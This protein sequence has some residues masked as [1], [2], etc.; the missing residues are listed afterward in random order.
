LVVDPDAEDIYNALGGIYSKLGRHEEA[1]AMMQRYVQL[2][3]DEP[4]AYDSLALIYQWAGQYDR[5][6]QAYH[7][8][9]ALKPDFEISIVNLG[10]LYFQ[11]GRYRTAINQYERYL[12]LARSDMER[13]K[14]YGCLAWVYLKQG[15][16]EKAEAAARKELEYGQGSSVGNSLIAALSRG[17]HQR[18]DELKAQLF[19]ASPYTHRGARPPLR[20]L[21]Y[22]LG[23]YALK[24]GQTAEAI[25][26]FQ[27]ALKHLP[28]LGA[29]DLLEDCL[30]NAY[31][32]LGQPD[33]AIAEYERVLK[34]NPHYPLA[35]YHLGQAYDRK[36][37]RERARTAYERFLQ[38]WKDA[39]PGIPEVME[40]KARVGREP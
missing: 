30:A 15:D 4:N 27:K 29:A 18:A 36:G 11:Q 38:I 6:Q 17:D 26:Q 3:P 16:L 12:K 19:A 7:R 25:A 32:E 9:L 24:R 22:F 20:Y 5:A 21:Y 34:T 37:D 33:Q 10:N 8:A 39:D 1:I 40:A 2:A 31:L 23:S 28:P 35:Q 14:G 13:E